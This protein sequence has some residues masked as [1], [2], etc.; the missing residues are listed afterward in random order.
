MLQK[1]SESKDKEHESAASRMEIT[2]ISS[3]KEDM[4]QVLSPPSD[5]SIIT[6]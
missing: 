5:A 6:I 2:K 1:E 3:T 4:I